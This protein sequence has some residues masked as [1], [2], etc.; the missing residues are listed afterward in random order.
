MLKKSDCKMCHRL[1][2]VD[3]RIDFNIITTLTNILLHSKF[4]QSNN[5]FQTNQLIYCESSLSLQHHQLS[6]WLPKTG[7]L[8]DKNL[9][10]S[11]M[12]SHAEVVTTC[13]N[14]VTGLPTCYKVVTTFSRPCNRI[15]NLLQG[16]D[17]LVKTL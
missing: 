5:W 9:H 7:S 13:Y 11:F 8:T 2:I 14:L 17:N 16:A 4:F 10:A 12:V 15:V 1:M 6:R 3:A